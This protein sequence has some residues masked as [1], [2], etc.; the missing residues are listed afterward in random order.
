MA[1]EDFVLV[2]Q[3]IDRTFARE[4]S[5]FGTGCVGH[6]SVA[7]P[8]CTRLSTACF[9]A[10]ADASITVHQGGT[11]LAME[12]PQF[13]TRAENRVYRESWGDDVIEMTNMPEAKL[14]HEAELCYACFAVVTDYDSWTPNHGAVE[15]TDIITVLTGKADKVRDMVQRLPTVLARPHR[16]STESC[17][18]ALDHAISTPPEHR[19]RALVAKLDA[20]ARR[21]LS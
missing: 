18:N 8:T 21:V 2:G 4:K 19:N 14:A 13:S 9:S 1:P 10:A 20:M 11:Y 5:F 12:G 16:L 3:F 15:I 17:N 6:V 7:Q